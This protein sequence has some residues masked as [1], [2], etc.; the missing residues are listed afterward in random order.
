LHEKCIPTYDEYMKTAHVTLGYTLL[1]G[2][3]FLG[4]GRLATDEAFQWTSQTVG[5]VKDACI[6]GRLISDVA[7][8]KVCTIHLFAI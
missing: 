4:M 6:I 1:T 7:S 5:L 3:A 8:H 2:V